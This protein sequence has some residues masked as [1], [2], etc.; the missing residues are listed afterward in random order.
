M[1][2]TVIATFGVIAV[3]V[4]VFILLLKRKKVTQ[5]SKSVP[6]DSPEPTPIV[7]DTI[8]NPTVTKRKPPVN[9]QS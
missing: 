5:V 7:Q 9:P 6:T 1:N 3:I 2:T 8:Y 4:I